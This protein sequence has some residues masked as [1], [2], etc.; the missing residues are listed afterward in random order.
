MV[1]FTGK[2]RKSADIVLRIGASYGFESLNSLFNV[3]FT[4][5]GTQKFHKLGPTMAT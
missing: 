3:P 5:E 1:S 4:Y 2:I